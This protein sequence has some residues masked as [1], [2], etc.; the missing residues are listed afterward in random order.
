MSKDG[1]TAQDHSKEPPMIDIESEDVFTLTEATRQLPKLHSGKR[2]HVSTLFRW[3]ERGIKGVRLETI[4][5]GGRVC[6]SR[7]ALHRFFERLSADD[8]DS[9]PAP[10]RMPSIGN[11]ERQLDEAGF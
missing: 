1:L 9:L 4:R 8:T 10:V 2:P 3:A 6:T 11:V 7:E 5:I